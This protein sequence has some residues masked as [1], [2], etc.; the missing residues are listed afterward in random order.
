MSGPTAG[1]QRQMTTASDVQRIVRTM[2]TLAAS[3]VGQHERAMVALAAYAETVERGLSVCFARAGVGLSPAIVGPAA[4]GRS[5]AIVF[6]S[7]QGLVGQFNEAISTFVLAETAEDRPVVWTVGDRVRTRL[8]DEGVDVAAHF[9]VPFAV[10]A[11]AALV[12]AVLL[13]TQ[14]DGGVTNLRLFFNRPNDMGLYT[15]TGLQVLPLDSA[16]VQRLLRQPWPTSHPAEV[17]GDASTT[18]RALIREYLFIVLF[19]ACAESLASEN[20]SRLAAM[21]RADRNIDEVLGEL[22]TTF[23]RLRHENIDEEMFDVIA[24]FE[25]LPR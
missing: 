12:G 25:A 11:I 7:D 24:G 18:L 14:G 22:R 15:P 4:R 17:L 13:Q 8:Q 19:R 1:I 5:V 20:A 21:E 6:G 3:S 10:D 2:K 16:W 9:A 23:H